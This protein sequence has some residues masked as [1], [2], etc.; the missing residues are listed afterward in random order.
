MLDLLRNF[1]LYF[2]LRFIVTSM[3]FVGRLLLCVDGVVVCWLSVCLVVHIGHFN[4]HHSFT[5]IYTI[6]FYNI[7]INF[8][9]FGFPTYFIVWFRVHHCLS[10]CVFYSLLLPRYCF[11]PMG[12]CF[13][14][15]TK[16]PPTMTCFF[17]D[18]FVYCF[19]LLGHFFLRDN[20]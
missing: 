3:F 13:V 4:Y 19:F 8:F 7:F 15:I 6:H 14:L 17:R 1:C 12:I 5:N 16:K 20:D 18:W 10:R 2:F 11:W 9:P